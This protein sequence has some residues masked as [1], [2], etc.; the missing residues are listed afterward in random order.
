MKKGHL[1]LVLAAGIYVASFR[2]FL[3]PHLLAVPLL[4]ATLL[5]LQ[6]LRVRG[7]KIKPPKKKK[8]V[9][10]TRPTQRLRAEKQ[11][12]GTYVAL[13]LMLLIGAGL[14][15]RSFGELLTVDRGFQSESRLVVEVNL[16]VAAEGMNPV[17]GLLNEFL[18]R[19]D[20]LPQVQSVSAVSMRPIAGGNTGM[21][22]VPAGAV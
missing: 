8:P 14:L 15:I 17:D 10:R 2:L 1:L 16:P 12:R 20:A 22:I 3:R 11:S 7:V 13:A 18:P 21:G 5:L 4:A 19:V 6:R 9:R